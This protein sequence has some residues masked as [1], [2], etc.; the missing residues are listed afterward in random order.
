MH[1]LAEFPYGALREGVSTPN[2][3]TFTPNPPQKNIGK[4]ARALK[5]KLV[6]IFSEACACADSGPSFEDRCRQALEA[7][8]LVRAAMPR[9]SRL[10]H[11]RPHF[12]PRLPHM[13]QTHKFAV[14]HLTIFYH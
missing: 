14:N 1:C 12:P 11:N 10:A 5:V 7:D 6:W 2:I 3:S 4:I 8:S 13:M 9:F